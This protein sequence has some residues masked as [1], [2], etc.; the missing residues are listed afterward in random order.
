MHSTRQ[1]VDL[2]KELATYSRATIRKAGC[3]IVDKDR[4]I[5]SQGFTT[6]LAGKDVVHAEIATLL[7]CQESGAAEMFVTAHPCKEC[8]KAII[9][10]RIRVVY[11]PEPNYDSWGFSEM[12]AERMFQDNGVQ[13]KQL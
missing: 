7:N 13:W 2:T 4:N 11:S 6:R 8:A 9:Y 10:A 3:V 5:L 1:L 12:A